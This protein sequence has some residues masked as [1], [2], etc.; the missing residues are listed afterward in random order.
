MC[1]KRH[2]LQCT[3][4]FWAKFNCE[5]ILDIRLG[6]VDSNYGNKGLG[7]EMLEANLSLG[8]VLGIKVNYVIIPFYQNL[9][10]E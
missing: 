9:S 5:E 4:D 8:K 1:L 6:A 3:G 10:I 2:L 7:R